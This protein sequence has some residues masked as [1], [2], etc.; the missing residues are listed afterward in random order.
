MVYGYNNKKM[1]IHNA[2]II[3]GPSG[4]GKGT[5]INKI[6]EKYQIPISISHTT[7]K[8]REGEISGVDYFFVNNEEFF[9]LVNTQKFIEWEQVHDNYY[10]THILNIEKIKE[11]NLLFEVD[12]KGAIN[13]MNRL[14]LEKGKFIS[15]FLDAPNKEELINR[16]KL[17]GSETEE[18][19]R[20]RMRTAEEEF[21]KKKH[22]DYIVVND[23][24]TSTFSKVEEILKHKGVLQDEA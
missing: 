19:I 1:K 4:V 20:T 15:I 7:R 18:S 3:S 17:R 23:T 24:I 6:K 21:Y 10:G 5:I 2:I 12:V 11:T 9:E 14:K 22:F 8:P 13:L 16:L